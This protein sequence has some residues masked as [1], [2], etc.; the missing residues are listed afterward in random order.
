M[1][2]ASI[3]PEISREESQLAHSVNNLQEG[4]RVSSSDR[5]GMWDE[6]KIKKEIAILRDVAPL[7]A[8]AAA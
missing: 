3:A 5:P 6:A 7:P 2:N 4:T 8:A 1:A